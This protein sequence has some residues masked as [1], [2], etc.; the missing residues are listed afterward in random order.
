MSVTHRRLDEMMKRSR[1]RRRVRGGSLVLDDGGWEVRY[2]KG[3][4]VY[5]LDAHHRFA[6]SRAAS[7]TFSHSCW[8][9]MSMEDRYERARLL[10]EQARG[11]GTEAAQGEYVSDAEFE[12]NYP[13]LAAFLFTPEERK[14]TEAD[15]AS[16]TLFAE[17][18]DLK[19]VLND[20]ARSRSLWATGRTVTACFQGLE[21]RLGLDEVSWRPNKAWKGKK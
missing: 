9:A 2:L 3:T 14:G 15:R 1:G 16:L 20:K 5:L 18:C 19:I 7:R 21:D 4:E 10:V 8:E 6:P 17:G 12:A 13:Y 11:R